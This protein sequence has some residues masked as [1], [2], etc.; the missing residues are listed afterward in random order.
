[1]N[2][3]K[4]GSKTFNLLR[5]AIAKGFAKGIFF[6][7][8]FFVVITLT[9]CNMERADNNG[10]ALDKES[11]SSGYITQTEASQAKM[12]P[13]MAVAMLKEGNARFADESM[14]NRDLI[15]QVK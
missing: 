9:S 4:T 5:P 1:M 10:Q 2:V 7:T 15:S 14:V 13:E 12:S 8:I 3:M 11:S 6:S